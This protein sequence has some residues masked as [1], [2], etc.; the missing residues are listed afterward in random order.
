[1]VLGQGYSELD[2]SEL[3]VEGRDHLHLNVDQVLARL[4]DVEP[5]VNPDDLR[6]APQC[7]GSPKSPGDALSAE[8]VEDLQVDST[9]GEA[10]D[11]KNPSFQ[12]EA[13]W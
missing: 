9:T 6:C 10:Q 4:D 3:E 7:K 13:S 2:G 8:V 12:L 5:E 1:M 11:H